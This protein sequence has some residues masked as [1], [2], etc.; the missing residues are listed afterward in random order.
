MVKTYGGTEEIGYPGSHSPS[1]GIVV[2]SKT[3]LRGLRYEI[4]NHYDMLKN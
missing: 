4:T 2:S 1:L 3:R